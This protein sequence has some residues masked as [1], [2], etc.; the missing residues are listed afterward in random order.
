MES[1]IDRYEFIELR[2]YDIHGY[3]KGRLLTRSAFSKILDAGAGINGGVCYRGINAQVTRHRMFGK[4]V[5]FKNIRLKPLLETLRP[6]M[7]IVQGDHRIG[8]VLCELRFEDGTL[9]TGSPREATLALLEQL[10]SEFG[11]KIK[12]S[13]E[14]EFGVRDPRTNEPFVNNI[15]WGSL[16][17]MQLSQPLMLGMVKSVDEIGVKIDTLIPE[18]GEGQFE[19]TFDVAEGIKRSDIAPGSPHVAQKESDIALGSPH[20]AQKESDIAPG[21]PHV[22]QKESDIALGSPHVAQKE[23][24]IA[25]GSPH[26]AQKESEIALGRPRVAQKESA[27]QLL[28]FSDRNALKAFFYLMKK[29]HMKHIYHPAIPDFFSDSIFYLSFEITPACTFL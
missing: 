10:H 8:S 6:C 1:H 3:T 12:S 19:V 16:A 17:I 5:G 23:S 27:I 4:D 15:K 20:V 26:V 2:V 13:F 7:K 29:Y 28:L 11:L 21:S 18:L 25:L 9:D 14:A 22:A 24:D